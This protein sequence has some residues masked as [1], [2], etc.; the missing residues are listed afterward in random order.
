MV[1]KCV[2]FKGNTWI[3]DILNKCV[4]MC[5]KAFPINPFCLRHSV[6]STV[7][8]FESEHV[9]LNFYSGYAAKGDLSNFE[10][11]LYLNLWRIYYINN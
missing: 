8:T 2:L 1:E 10:K 4:F 11:F 7:E 3:S 6:M 9:F 5:L